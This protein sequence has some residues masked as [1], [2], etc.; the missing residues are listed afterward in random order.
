MR[1]LFGKMK[2]AFKKLKA[3]FT[4]KKTLFI[5]RE[6]EYIKNQEALRKAYY[7]DDIDKIN[8]ARVIPN[9]DDDNCASFSIKDITQELDNNHNENTNIDIFYDFKVYYKHAINSA[10]ESS[11]RSIGQ[12]KVAVAFLKSELLPGYRKYFLEKIFCSAVDDRSSNKENCAAIACGILRGSTYH[13]IFRNMDSYYEMLESTEA[14][15]SYD[16]FLDENG[17]TSNL[18]KH[19]LDPEKSN[20]EIINIAVSLL[21]SKRNIKGLR[22]AY[23]DKIFGDAMNRDD[24][25][26]GLYVDIA[27]KMIKV[28]SD[29]EDLAP[30]LNTHG[31]FGNISP[32]IP[33][34]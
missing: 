19:A 14:K 12:L 9:L 1:K 15:D 7:G 16:L 4:K 6:K 8:F 31:P 29:E 28:E 20:K 26:Q 3:S 18:L 32:V 33:N 22:Q 34:I 23:I 21:S 24:P 25:N 27:T 30:I 10:I 13:E 11:E 2:K 5:E 17:Y